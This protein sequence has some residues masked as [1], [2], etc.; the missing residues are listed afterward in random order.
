MPILLL[1]WDGNP[2]AGEGQSVIRPKEH[3]VNLFRSSGVNDT[4]IGHFRMD[5]NEFLPCWPEAW[6]L[7]FIASIRPM[8]IS[9]HPETGPLYAKIAAQIGIPEE[10]LVVTAGS[11]AAIRSAFEVF[12][13]PDDEVIILNP[14][15]AMYSIYASIYLARLIEVDYDAELALSIDKIKSAITGRTKL[16]C[17]ANP[18]SPTGTVIKQEELADLVSHASQCG[19]A[20]LVDEAYFPFHKESLIHE[21]PGRDNLIVTRTFSKAAGMAGL[22]AGFLA[23]NTD[24]AKALFA[25]KPMYEITTLTCLAAEYVLD[26]YS[27][28]DEYADSVR[29]GRT[30][31][32][33]H[34]RAAGFDV[35]EGNANFLNVDFGARKQYI[36]AA[37]HEAGVLFKDHFSHP[38]LARYSRFTV[39]P[40]KYMQEFAELLDGIITRSDL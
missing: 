20:V 15:F 16:V 19:A 17:I 5:K 33:G 40:R 11:D 27:R 30:W 23:A 36:V 26:N 4:R 6:F 3:L 24:L 31:F 21:V 35:F 14:T 10:C 39:G 22:R 7:D 37:L 32:A 12:V 1:P 9:I 8:H 18:N 38:S 29:D 25:V 13:D 28:V 34:L 2:E